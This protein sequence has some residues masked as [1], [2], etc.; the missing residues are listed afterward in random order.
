[1]L[2]DDSGSVEEKTESGLENMESS[3]EIESTDENKAF[4]QLFCLPPSEILLSGLIIDSA[5]ISFL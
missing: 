4:L 5:Y 1:V 2:P 3:T